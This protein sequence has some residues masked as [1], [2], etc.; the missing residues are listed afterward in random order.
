MQVEGH[1]QLL[2]QL[3]ERPI[4]LQ[5]VIEAAIGIVPLGEPVDQGA[6]E[7]HLGHA[8]LQFDSQGWRWEDPAPAANGDGTW[9][10]L[11]VDFFLDKV[12]A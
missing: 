3:P 12:S 4:L 7:T 1:V 5:I 8:A 10:L 11:P 2:H 9:Q 6:D